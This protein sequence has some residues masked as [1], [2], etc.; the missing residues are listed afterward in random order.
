VIGPLHHDKEGINFPH[1]HYHIDGRFLPPHI[2]KHAY[3]SCTAR[4]AS[5]I[6]NFPLYRRGEEHVA[7]PVL[8]RRK[9]TNLDYEWIIP[10]SL[11]AKWG[12]IEKYGA[13]APAIHLKDGRILCPHRKANLSSF[14]PDENGRV[15][16]PLHGLV[17][18]C[19]RPLT[20]KQISDEGSASKLARFHREK[21]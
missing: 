7:L 8:K 5:T 6:N 11:T 15:R 10:D 20:V 2:A 9:C 1:N 14:P 21:C 3:E 18:D 12:L 13:P 16:C 4:I 19:T 17:V